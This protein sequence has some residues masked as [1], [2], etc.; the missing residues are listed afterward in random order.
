MKSNRESKKTRNR[1]IHGHYYGDE[2]ELREEELVRKISI[3]PV[4]LGN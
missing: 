4:S 3:H 1:L 2:M